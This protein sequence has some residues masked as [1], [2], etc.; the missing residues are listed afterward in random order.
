MPITKYIL[1][2][3]NCELFNDVTQE[4]GDYAW[5]PSGM[6]S[7][8]RQNLIETALHSCP[9]VSNGKNCP[10]TK[11]VPKVMLHSA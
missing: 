7:V 11:Y 4:G 10:L 3:W 9:Y 8:D 6:R 2:M 1:G 5:I